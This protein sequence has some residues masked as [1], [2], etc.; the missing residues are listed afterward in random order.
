MTDTCPFENRSQK[1]LSIESLQNQTNPQWL[2]FETLYFFQ[3]LFILL[4][5]NAFNFGRVPN[6]VAW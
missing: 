3:K 4:P 2:N 6:F 5:K 1:Q